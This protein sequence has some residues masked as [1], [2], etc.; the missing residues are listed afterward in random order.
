MTR[1]TFT[2]TQKPDAVIAGAGFSGMVLARIL[3]EN[4]CKVLVA[5]KRTHL[6]GNA[7]DEK[8][9]ATGL[10]VHRYG[11]HIFHT[12]DKAV[13][14][15][16]SRFTDWNGYQH[17]VLANVYGKLLPVPFNLD[18]LYLAFPENRA[19]ELEFK[20]LSRYGENTN[21]SILELLKTDDRELQTLGSYI[22]QNIFE[23]YTVKQWDKRPED[24]DPATTARVPVRLSRDDRYFTDLYQGLPQD[25]YTALFERMADHENIEIRT[26]TDALDMIRLSEPDKKLYFQ[27]KPFDGVFVY[28]GV[29]DKLLDGRFGALPYRSLDFS[30]EV[31]DTEFFQPCGTVNYTVNMLYTRITEFKHMTFEKAPGTVILKEYSKVCDFSRGDIPYYPVVSPESTACYEKYKTALAGF[32]NLY[33]VGRLAEY[34]YYNMDA[35]AARAMSLAGEILAAHFTCGVS[36]S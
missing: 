27:G 4:G 19:R 7:Y 17:K 16:L 35:A 34:R 2:D 23:T 11:P 26:E 5:E 25:G 3:A 8:E 15:F 31:H 10:T 22:Y 13:F 14:D 20:L 28:S 30:F 1:H 12:K 36:L 32:K 6:A 18:S 21:V 9:P 33:L 24:I 29:P